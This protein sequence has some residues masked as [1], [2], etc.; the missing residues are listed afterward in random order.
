L[1][2]LKPSRRTYLATDVTGSYPRAT[3][4]TWV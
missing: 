4:L 3:F 2:D 1:L